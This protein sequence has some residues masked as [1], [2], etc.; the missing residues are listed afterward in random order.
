MMIVQRTSDGAIMMVA[1][2]P[3]TQYDQ[4]AYTI[5]NAAGWDWSRV[6]FTGV[7]RTQSDWVYRQMQWNGTTLIARVTQLPSRMISP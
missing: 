1:N 7:D 6:N 3:T 2:C 4:S 5:I